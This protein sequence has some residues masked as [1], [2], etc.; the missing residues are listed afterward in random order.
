MTALPLRVELFHTYPSTRL[1][2]RIVFFLRDFRLFPT[3]TDKENLPKRD[4][5]ISPSLFFF[6]IFEVS[7]HDSKENLHGK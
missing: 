3:D 2:G 7:L 6:P 5:F 4:F 1:S